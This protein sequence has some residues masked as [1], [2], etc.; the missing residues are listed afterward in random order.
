MA[1]IRTETS[2]IQFYLRYLN[3]EI[4]IPIRFKKV[5]Y[6]SEKELFWTFWTFNCILVQCTVAINCCTVYTNCLML[7]AT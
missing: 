7:H 3:K 1:R 4:N 6:Y 2:I 5:I